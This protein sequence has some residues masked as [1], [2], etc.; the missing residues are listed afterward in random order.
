M[1]L[2]KKFRKIISIYLTRD[3]DTEKQQV[4][5]AENARSHLKNMESD[6]ERKRFLIDGDCQYLVRKIMEIYKLTDD[7]EGK[8]SEIEKLGN[9]LMLRNVLPLKI[10]STKERVDFMQEFPLFY[11]HRTLVS[12]RD[13]DLNRP[14]ES[15]DLID[16]VSYVVPI[17]Y[18]HYV[19]GEK[20]FIELAKQA[21]L[22]ILYNTI[23]CRK[24]TELKPHL[25]LIL[26]E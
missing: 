22:D 1:K 4:A 24:L 25:E 15:N 18:F 19:V 16:I 11:T 12:F 23:L 5:N 21:K 6:K 26:N 20:Y 13:R 9:L 17:V 3:R 8:I 2:I 14:I 7:F 10:H